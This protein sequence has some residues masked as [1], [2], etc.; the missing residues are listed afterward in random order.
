MIKSK[1]VKKTKNLFYKILS[2]VLAVVSAIFLGMLFYIDL[3]PT[4]YMKI[5]VVII[6]IFNLFNIV[7]LNHNRLK[8]KVRKVLSSIVIFSVFIMNTLEIHFQLCY[9]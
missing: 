9:N 1:K 2:V 5:L 7:L 8:K 4:K 3:I 6:L